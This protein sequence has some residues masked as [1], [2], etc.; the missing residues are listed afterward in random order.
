VD[1]PERW[2]RWYHRTPKNPA[3]TSTA[4]TARL[5]P[6]ATPAWPELLLGCALSTAKRPNCR[7]AL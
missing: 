6:I 3:T 2:W 4:H 1:T 5:T 7:A